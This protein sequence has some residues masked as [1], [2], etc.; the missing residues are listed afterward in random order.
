[1]AKAKT[2]C[3]VRGCPRPAAVKKHRLC[4]AHYRRW[5]RDRDVGSATVLERRRPI[6]TYPGGK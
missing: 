4:W 5:Q 6:T 1:M 3:A 2:L